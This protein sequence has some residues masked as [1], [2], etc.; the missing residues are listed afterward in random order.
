MYR[1]QEQER[2]TA[3][4]ARIDS[5]DAVDCNNDEAEKVNI[6]KHNKFCKTHF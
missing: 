5:Y 3:L 6:L 1:Q 2:L 4:A